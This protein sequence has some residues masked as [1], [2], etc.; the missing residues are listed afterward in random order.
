MGIDSLIVIMVGVS[1]VLLILALTFRA[2]RELYKADENTLIVCGEG[3]FLNP[4]TDEARALVLSGI[5]EILK[6]Y[7][8]ENL[9]LNCWIFMLMPNSWIIRKI[10]M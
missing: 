6:K 3:I 2:E 10:D 8:V 5:R 4:A 1:V 7:R 9:T